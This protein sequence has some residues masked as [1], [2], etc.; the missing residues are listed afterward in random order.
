M[1]S[2]PPIIEETDIEATVANHDSTKLRLL[3][4]KMESNDRGSINT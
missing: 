2:A 4:G 3:P 1:N